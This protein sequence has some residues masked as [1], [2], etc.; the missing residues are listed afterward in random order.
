[1]R[2]K[3]SEVMAAWI[4]ANSNKHLCACGCGEY[5]R[6]RPRYGYKTGVVP[7]YVNA[8]H[9][10]RLCET[11]QFWKHA[12]KAGPNECWLWQG[13][14][15]HGY[16]IIGKSGG[17]IGAHRFSYELHN[18][19]IPAGMHVC[20]KCDIRNCVNPSH[21]FVGTISDNM[22]D[23]VAKGR[24]AAG[25]KSGQAK[26]TA[27]QVLEIRSA[28]AAGE[29][30]Q[31]VSDRYGVKR[32]TVSAIS[33]GTNWRR[34]QMPEFDRAAT[35]ATTITLTDVSPLGA[36]KIPGEIKEAE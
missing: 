30:H 26:L 5:L 36:T 31:S 3:V 32:R 21:L 33:F 6:P 1:M 34:L 13:G 23:K 2:R 8:G 16:G 18:G 29:T 35:K 10:R 15:S 7:K 12:G 22:A 17:N 28:C 4:E 9:A 25:E 20:H 24:Q 14:T 11:E 27:V 19:P